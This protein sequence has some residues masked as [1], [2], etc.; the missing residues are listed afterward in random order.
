MPRQ[1]KTARAKK[2]VLW[3]SADLKALRKSA[4]KKG[5]A[6]IARE[7]KRSPAAVQLKASHEGISLRRR[8]A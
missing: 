5:L 1:K 8:A 6:Q 4:G 7:L 2:R 3:T